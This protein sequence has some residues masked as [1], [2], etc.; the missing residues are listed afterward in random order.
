MPK[1]WVLCCIEELELKRINNTIQI[2][3]QKETIICI[4]VSNKMVLNNTEDYITINLFC[5]I[6][7]IKLSL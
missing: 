4:I 6:H 7:G 2:I 5:Y 3:Q 1:S